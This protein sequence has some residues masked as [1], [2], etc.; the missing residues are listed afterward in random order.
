MDLISQ[1]GKVVFPV[2]KGAGCFCPSFH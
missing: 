2:Q 1:E